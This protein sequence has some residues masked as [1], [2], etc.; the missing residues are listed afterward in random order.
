MNSVYYL[1]IFE[2]KKKNE[3]IREPSLYLLPARNV[4]GESSR[5][6]DRTRFKSFWLNEK[7][8]KKEGRG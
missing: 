8:R 4:L 5:E 7:K 1:K 3:V 6:K 2:K